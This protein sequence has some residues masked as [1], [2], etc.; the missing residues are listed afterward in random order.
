MT[1]AKIQHYVPQFLLRN[2]GSGKKDC[3][4]VLD[5]SSDTIF[6]SNAKNIVCKRRLNTL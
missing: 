6:K 2:F 4:W 5:K 1:T 3:V